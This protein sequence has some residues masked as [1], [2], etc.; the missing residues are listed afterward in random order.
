[1]AQQMLGLADDWE[2]EYDGDED[3]NP[4]NIPKPVD[5]EQEDRLA[6]K[7]TLHEVSRRAFIHRPLAVLQEVDH[8]LGGGGRC[9]SSSGS[10][11]VMDVVARR[12]KEDRPTSMSW[13][14][15]RLTS[16]A[17]ECFR[18]MAL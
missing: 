8:G 17:N 13:R 6:R 7:P 12:A 5:D 16:T 4:N 18:S 11:L 15:C 9:A 1:M 14:W 10:P 2:A 3:L